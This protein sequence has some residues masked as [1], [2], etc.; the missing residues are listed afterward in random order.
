MKLS[1]K[2]LGRF[3]GTIVREEIKRQLP[4]MIR[5]CLTENYIRKI[6]SENASV[7]EPVVEKKGKLSLDFLKENPVKKTHPMN[8]SMRKLLGEENP[9]SFI[10]ED[11]TIP[12][13]SP[14]I[15]IEKMGLDFEKMRTL[16]LGKPGSNLPQTDP[17]AKKFDP[18]L[19]TPVGQR[20]PQVAVP[21]ARRVP[22]ANPF[23]DPSFAFPDKPIVPE[24]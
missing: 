6:V 16:A 22:S 11:V 14:T 15:P 23:I 12:K 7:D 10:Y 9:M 1:S 19:D 4:G 20:P 5:E 13:E 8:E 18:T 21:Q 2:D 17:Q 3:I 24:E